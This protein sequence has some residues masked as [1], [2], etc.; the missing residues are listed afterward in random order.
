MRKTLLNMLRTLP[1]ILCLVLSAV[2][3]EAPSPSARRFVRVEYDAEGKYDPCSRVLRLEGG[4]VS[5]RAGPG[6]HFAVVGRL[7]D[8]GNQVIHSCDDWPVQTG[9]LAE[10]VREWVGI[11]YSDDPKA[12]CFKKPS[13]PGRWRYRGTCEQGW[14]PADRVATTAG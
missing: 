6:R 3:A 4:F 9:T 14:I 1:S 8:A 13:R 2:A 12:D 11:V 5:V 7:R 10:G